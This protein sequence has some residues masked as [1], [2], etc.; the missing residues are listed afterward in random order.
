MSSL[1]QG[2]I[3]RAFYSVLTDALSVPVVQQR[4]P[5][6]EAGA[7]LVLLPTPAS[8]PRQTLKQETGHSLTQRVR[9]HTRHPKGKA[10]LSEREGIASQA[11]LAITGT[12][13]Q[14]DGMRFIRK[15]PVEVTPQDY[16]T[17]GQHAY[18]LLLDY[19]IDT[20]TIG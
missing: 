19:D 5:K 4:R 3:R 17:G 12:E 15:P 13:L 7:P 11:H 18:D 6:G 14:A 20:Q 16:E 2:P 10:D 9:V 8:T 1:P